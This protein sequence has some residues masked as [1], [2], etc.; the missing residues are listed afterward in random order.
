MCI[1][2]QSRIRSDGYGDRIL[3]IYK[4]LLC[5]HAADTVRFA[6]RNCAKSL[7]EFDFLRLIQGFGTIAAVAVRP[8]RPVPSGV[9]ASRKPGS[10][11]R[12][13]AQRLRNRTDLRNPPRFP[14]CAPCLMASCLM[15]SCRGGDRRHVADASG[16]GLRDQEAAARAVRA[17][18]AVRARSPCRAT[19]RRAGTRSDVC[20]GLTLGH[21][22]CGGPCL[23]AEIMSAEIGRA[24]QRGDRS[25]KSSW[26]SL[27]STALRSDTAQNA[28]PACRQPRML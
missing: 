26:N 25:A 6:A 20:T 12:R 5:T 11:R 18:P 14:V 2:R 10:F 17:A 3:K 24:T 23:S 16:L 8:V 27:S 7:P 9:C 13:F 21:D 4:L 22:R 1:A 15:A 19:P 28:R